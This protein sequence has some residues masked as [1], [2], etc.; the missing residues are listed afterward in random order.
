[1]TLDIKEAIAVAPP[2]AVGPMVLLGVPLPDIVL[3]A[4]LTWTL[5]LIVEKLASI[6]QSR[7]K[8]R[9]PNG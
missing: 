8:G 4:T 1:M 6:Y 3:L 9:D 2:S 7:K 5:I